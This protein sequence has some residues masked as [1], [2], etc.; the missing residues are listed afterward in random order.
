[1]IFSFRICNVT[2]LV[3][4]TT[5]S[6]SGCG[7]RCLPGGYLH[8]SVNEKR[9]SCVVEAQVYQFYLCIHDSRGPI[10]CVHY[11]A[12]CNVTMVT[13]RRGHLDNNFCHA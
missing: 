4:T 5:G 1:M 8:I 9:P 7:W 11:C 13:A 10:Q 6:L 2:F 12:C 3:C